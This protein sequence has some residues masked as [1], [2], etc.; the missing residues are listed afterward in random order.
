[1]GFWASRS[2]DQYFYR[3]AVVSRPRTSEADR[4]LRDRDVVAPFWESAAAFK[5]A[6]LAALD[7]LAADCRTTI[8]AGQAFEVTARHPKP[9][10]TTLP[11]TGNVR[12]PPAIRQ[13]VLEQADREIE[14]RRRLVREHAAA[15]HAAAVATFPDLPQ[16]SRPRATGK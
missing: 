7:R 10:Y 12:V 11:W 15:M 2:D 5:A 9:G 13:S 3:A 4:F 6:T 14:A 8:A 1:M 16:L